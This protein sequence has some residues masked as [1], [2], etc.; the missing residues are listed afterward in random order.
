MKGESKR[1]EGGRGLLQ[2][3]KWGKGDCI[4][5]WH[6]THMAYDAAEQANSGSSYTHRPASAADV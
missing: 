4:V 6:D 2:W 1:K 5:P 3:L